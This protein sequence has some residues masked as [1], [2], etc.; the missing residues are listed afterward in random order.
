[1]ECASGLNELRKP[2]NNATDMGDLV[3][4]KAFEVTT[5]TDADKRGMQEAINGSN[6]HLY[7]KDSAGL[8]YFAGHA[9]EVYGHN[10]VIAI[11]RRD[12]VR[13]FVRNT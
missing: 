13:N 6:Q 8:F 4:R 5:L 7:L 3:N 12:G 11:V 2:V 9:V 1:M 10:Y